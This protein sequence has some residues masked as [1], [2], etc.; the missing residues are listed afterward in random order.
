MEAQGVQRGQ[1]RQRREKRVEVQ[2][3]DVKGAEVQASQRRTQAEAGHRRRESIHSR[4]VLPGLQGE[5][6]ECREGR[7]GTGRI[8]QLT[9]RAQ[10]RVRLPVKQGCR[11]ARQQVQERGGGAGEPVSRSSREQVYVRVSEEND[12]GVRAGKLRQ[13]RVSCSNLSDTG[14]N[15]AMV[16]SSEEGRSCRRLNDRGDDDDRELCMLRQV[17][18]R[19]ASGDEQSCA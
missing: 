5:R 3:R 17:I 18:E 19:D 12:A 14:R 13:R 9:Q 10:A 1:Q 11:D 4:V 15:W 8:E 7:D 16:G 6:A 2:L